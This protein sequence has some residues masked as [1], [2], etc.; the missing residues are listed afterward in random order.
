MEQVPLQILSIVQET[1][2]KYN[3]IDLLRHLALELKEA[4]LEPFVLGFAI[5]IKKVMEENDINEDQIE[6][7][8]SDFASYC[9]KHNLSFEELIQ[10]GYK[11]LLLE[12]EFRVS[13]E[14]I[15]EYISKSK[16][17]LDNLEN[18]IKTQQSKLHGV[19]TTYETLNGKLEKIKNEYSAIEPSQ[20]LRLELE[21]IKQINKS[22]SF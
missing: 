3:D 15:P 7:I 21:E 5:R 9:Y 13:I 6:P 18:Q 19:W 20:K 16:Q 22:I 12:E 10:S 1:S 11:A 8:N 4:G 17:I 2:K 14:K